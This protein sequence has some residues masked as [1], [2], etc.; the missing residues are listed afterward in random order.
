MGGGVVGDLLDT[1]AVTILV[2]AR[3]GQCFS[4]SGDVPMWFQLPRDS[5][6]RVLFVAAE[7]ASERETS[8]LA[9]ARIPVAAMLIS[10]AHDLP[11]PAVFMYRRGRL[12]HGGRASDT[13]L[14][15]SILN[16]MR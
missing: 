10:P 16:E 4:C 13:I 3:P 1:A 12:V 7:Q 14:V 6:R 5:S 11:M 2:L 15:H 8:A 9:I